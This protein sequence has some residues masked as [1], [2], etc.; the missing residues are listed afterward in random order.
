MELSKVK[1][2]KPQ[3]RTAVVCPASAEGVSA[4]SISEI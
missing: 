2:A 1:S 3:I 4:V